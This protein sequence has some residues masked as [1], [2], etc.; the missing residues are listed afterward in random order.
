MMDFDFK[1]KAKW[2]PFWDTE[3]KELTITCQNNVEMADDLTE[4]HRLSSP[5]LM[6]AAPKQNVKHI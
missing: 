4:N 1:N 2:A 5:P 6:Y 3:H